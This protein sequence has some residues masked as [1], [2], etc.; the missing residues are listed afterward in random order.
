PTLEDVARAA[1]VSRAT[2]S[3]RRAVAGRVGALDRAVR[4]LTG[5]EGAVHG[6]RG[7]VGRDLVELHRDRFGVLC[8]CRCPIGC[9]TAQLRPHDFPRSTHT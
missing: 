1:G 9:L 7:G 5:G 8:G 6:R 4:T 2:V 3:E